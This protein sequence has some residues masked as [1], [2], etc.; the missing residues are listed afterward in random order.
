MNMDT[1]IP[2]Y[3]IYTMRIGLIQLIKE[4]FHHGIPVSESTGYE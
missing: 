4:A 3:R 1:R 2:S